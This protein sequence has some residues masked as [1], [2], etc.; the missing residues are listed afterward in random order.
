MLWL[1]SLTLFLSAFLLFFIQPMVGKMILPSLGGTPA[2]WNTCMVFFQA[3]L[4]AGY[5]LAHGGVRTLGIRRQPVLHLLLV[6]L[7]L[8]PVLGLLPLS[9]PL[10]G[11]P[12]ESN[13]P[14][15]WLLT[16]LAIGVGLPFL[17]IATNAPVLQMWFSGTSHKAARDPYFLYGASNIGSLLALVGYPILIERYLTLDDQARWWMY[18][19]LALAGLLVLCAIG[20]WRSRPVG[21]ADES[22]FV[23]NSPPEALT[24]G[25]RLRWVL[26]AFVPSSLM[27]GATTHITTD[28]API[29]LLWVVPLALYVLSFVLVF[30]RKPPIEHRKVMRFFPIILAAVAL[31]SVQNAVPFGLFAMVAHLVLQFWA[32][33]ACHGELVKDRPEVRHLTQFYLW[34]SV[35][36]VLGGIFN[37]LLAP[38]AFDTILEY[39]LVMVVACFVLA[40][41]GEYR[42]RPLALDVALGLCVGGLTF[43]LAWLMLFRVHL[44]P[45]PE[46]LTTIVIPTAF[47]LAAWIMR[48]RWSTLAI[49]VGACLLA[50]AFNTRLHPNKTIYQGRNFYGVKAVVEDK[51]KTTHQLF[52]GT[53]IHGLQPLHPKARNL[54][55]SYYHKAGPI[56]DLFRV[57]GDEPRSRNVAVIGLGVGGLAAYCR[58]TDRFV[59]YE[60]D[61]EMEAIA[62]N[63]DYFTY[64]ADCGEACSVVLGDGRMTIQN[65]PDGAYDIIF[66]D[67]FTSDA[68]PTHLLTI[69]AL[70]IYLSK[71]SDDGLLV[72]N[73]TN[74]YLKLEYVLR[75]LAD[76][77]GLACIMRN[78]LRFDLRDPKNAGRSFCQYTIMARRESRLAGLAAL[79]GWVP[80]RQN[81][82]VGLWTDKRTNVFSVLDW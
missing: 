59:F 53:T 76:A 9:V 60:I 23:E 55:M 69:E 14:V 74:R 22:T 48:E 6:A 24:I 49:T 77:G 67:A 58:P 12:T 73:M 32:A 37:G 1:Y 50:L 43:G 44:P 33:M 56:G 4:L 62:R 66:L 39:P 64:L 13:N 51:A 52:C 20:L 38:V 28:I 70:E 46:V 61:P 79:Q 27:L 3:A 17:A 68:V 30:A 31:M 41:S 80:P 57:L 54:P 26:L 35:G 63:P 81:P 78:D 15:W 2:V 16:R 7:P 29:P 71:L 42:P 72:F 8:L 34:M 18:G 75:N 65:A 5:L 47:C 19:Y 40:R 45:G 82:A 10:E 11:V 36:G 21:A 25:R